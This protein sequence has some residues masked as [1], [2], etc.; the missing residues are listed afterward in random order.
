MSIESVMP[1]NHLIL[2]HPFL[3]LPSILPS[4]R[5]FQM[6]QLF[7]SGGQNIGVSASTSVLP[8]NTQDWSPL[9]WTAWIS[10]SPRDSQESSPIPQFKSIN[11]SLLSFLYSPTLTSIHDYWKNHNFDYTTLISKVMSLLFIDH[12][13]VAIFVRPLFNSINLCVYVYANTILF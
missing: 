11:S 6:S 5:V 8:M 10:S 13:Y 4:I 9:E 1:S 7:A 12:V 2:C 3:L